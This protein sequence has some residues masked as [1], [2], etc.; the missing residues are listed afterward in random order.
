MIDGV[1]SI[2]QNVGHVFSPGSPHH[3]H[4]GKSVILRGFAHYTDN[5]DPES[6]SRLPVIL[7]L[8]SLSFPWVIS[9]NC[10]YHIVTLRN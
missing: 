3:S 7:N 4:S 5:S 10:T 1:T 6:G 2:W 9:V 8:T